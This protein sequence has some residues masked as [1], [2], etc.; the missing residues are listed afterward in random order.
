M[1]CK[2]VP[3]MD[4]KPNSKLDMEKCLLLT[5]DEM[6]NSSNKDKFYYPYLIPGNTDPRCLQPSSDFL[7]NGC[8]NT[9]H[10]CG[11]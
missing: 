7:E 2:Y 6:G 10:Q 1:A 8:G 5:K 9:Y 11:I 4:I 3:K